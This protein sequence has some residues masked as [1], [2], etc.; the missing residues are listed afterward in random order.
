V[1]VAPRTTVL[2]RWMAGGRCT[3]SVWVPAAAT[4]MGTPEA[5]AGEAGKRARGPLRAYA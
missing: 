3:A 2:A 1:P 5:K 4:P